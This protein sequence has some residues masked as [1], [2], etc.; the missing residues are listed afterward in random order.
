M[1]DLST[2]VVL[3]VAAE[4]GIDPGDLPPLNEVVDT[5]AL[6][7]LPG[8]EANGDAS[9][10]EYELRFSYAGRDVHVR[11]GEISVGQ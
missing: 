9:R 1:S 6:D 11:N 4:T 5:T 8:P 2:R 7:R 3:A 10:F